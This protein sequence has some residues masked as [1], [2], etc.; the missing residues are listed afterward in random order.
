MR[1]AGWPP[2]TGCARS[3]LDAAAG[4]RRPAGE[5]AQDLLRRLEPHARALGC[6]DE[7]AGVGDLLS[8][9]NG[10]ERQLM[11]YEANR[12]ARELAAEIVARTAAEPSAHDGVRGE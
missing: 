3:S 10:A 5:M 1:T 11:V 9:G 7:L 4:R 8:A 12:D 2:A 6:S